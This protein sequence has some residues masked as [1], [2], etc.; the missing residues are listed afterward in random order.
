M[1][2]PNSSLASK[3]VNVSV[4]EAFSVDDVAPTLTW[5]KSYH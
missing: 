5:F 4:A 1:L 3:G 2:K